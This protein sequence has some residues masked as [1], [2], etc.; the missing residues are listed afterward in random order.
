MKKR[1]CR[2]TPDEDRIHNEAVK[3]RK[4]TDEQLVNYVEGK[5]DRKKGPDLGKTV[6]EIM[7]GISEVKGVG[8]TKL[9]Y[10]QEIIEEK[11]E[12]A[13]G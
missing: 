10:I 2:R 5:T 9:H 3:L 13:Y 6:T 12:E 4:L 7:T 8:K 1:S 11:L